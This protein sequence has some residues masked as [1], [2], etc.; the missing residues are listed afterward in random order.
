MPVLEPVVATLLANTTQFVA[1]LETAKGEMGTFAVDS[2]A[3]GDAAGLGLAEGAANGAEGMGKDLEEAGKRSGGKFLKGITASLNKLGS[4]T[5]IPLGPL[6]EGLHKAT[7]ASG[8]LDTKS[9]GLFGKMQ[10]AGKIATLGL[11]AGFVGAAAEGFHLAQQLQSSTTAIS[12]ASDTSVAAAASIS[13]AFLDTA[14]TSEFSATEMASAYASVAGQLKSAEGAAL[15][16][17]QAMDVMSAADELA[18]AKQ[19]SLGEASK[20]VAGA[21]QAYHTPT[22]DA[23]ALTDVLLNVSNATGQSISATAGQLEKIKTRLGALTPPL[24]D[25]AGLLLDL[26]NHG[27]TG[28]QAMTVL[29][30]SFQNFLKPTEQ[31]VKAHRDLSIAQA[32]LPPALRSIAAEYLKGNIS[33]TAVSKATKGLTIDQTTLWSAYKKA[34]DATHT[35]YQAQE[36]LGIQTVDSHGKLLPMSQILGELH[37]KTKGM[38]D[39]TAEATLKAMGFGGNAAKLLPIVRA[40]AQEFDKNAAAAAKTGAAHKAA[41]AQAKTLSVEFKTMKAIVEDLLTKLGGALIPILQNVGKALGDV[42][43]WVMNCKPVLY[44]LAGIVGTVL[45]TAI[46]SYIASLAVATAQ[47]IVNFGKMIAAGA[48]WIVEQTASMAES[49]ALWAMYAADWMAT[50]IPA[51]TEFVTKNTVMLTTWITETASGVAET[52]ALWAMYA[53]DWL[54]SQI[55][56]MAT[57]VAEHAAMAAGFIAENLVM[58]ASATAAF[59]AENA[60]TLGIVAGIA[61][62]VGAIIW[63]ATHWKEVWSF[64][65]RIAEDV[66][67]FLDGIW[68]AIVGAVVAAWNFIKSHIKIIIETIFIIITGPI[69][70]LV[71]FLV[72]HWRTILHDVMAVW[73]DVI[74]FLGKIPGWILGI[75]EGAL[76]WLAGIGNDILTGLLNG[77]VDG[78]KAVWAWFK[79]LWKFILKYVGGAELWLLDVGIKMLKGLWNG[80]VKGATAVWNWFTGL[81]KDILNLLADAGTWL[82]DIG[83]KILDGLI[84]GIKKGAGGVWDAIKGVGH[85]IMGVFKDV[86]SIFSPSRVFHE[87]GEHLM[88]GLANGIKSGSGKVG[89]SMKGVT[90]SLLGGPLSG[91][92]SL[93]GSGVGVSAIVARPSAGAG[94]TTVLQVTTPIQINGQTI[95]Q[96][97]TQYQLRSARSTGTVL[98]QYSGGSQTGAATGINTNAISR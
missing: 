9:T 51:L 61:L 58:I 91:S 56:A 38:S 8:E 65:K 2:A 4:M 69:G 41:E 5:G 80:I 55:P 63:M 24:S 37:D 35:A 72:S 39:A 12:V 42:I 11:A 6:T 40:G 90:D 59:I 10:G 29:T 66:W 32:D 18:T 19:I 31:L 68:Q 86:L 82:L 95:A 21:M 1:S 22:K 13:Q 62:L 30:G 48:S 64:V 71:A 14:G 84:N 88:A 49:V 33:A 78:A 77:I 57:F 83:K 53:A 76:S 67:H 23:A 46:G 73:N 36:K 27:I 16:R 93:S 94:G 75:F 25:T 60:A 45:V 15:D 44:T 20:A 97:V 98:G 92:L 52:V 28:R 7:E 87:Y 89:D 34:A 43:N 3:L 54:G 17:K 26:T 81:G 74:G 96:T 85:G 47:S 50:Q 79:D 70:L